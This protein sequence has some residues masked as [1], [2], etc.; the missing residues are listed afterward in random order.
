MAVTAGR[1]GSIAIQYPSADLGNPATSVTD[2]TSLNT[3]MD[4]ATVFGEVRSWSLEESVD[5]L[6]ATVMSSSTGFIFRDVLPSFKSWTASVDYIY[7]PA[8]SG[9]GN[10]HLKAGN[11]VNIG[12]FPE[13]DTASV[14]V[15]GGKAMITSISQSASYDGLIEC[16]INVEGRAVLVRGDRT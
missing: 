15:W 2:I 12:V 1:N 6:D 8:D 3:A 10:V 14:E 5:T 11:T 9:Q 16:T 13:G 7:D 4:A